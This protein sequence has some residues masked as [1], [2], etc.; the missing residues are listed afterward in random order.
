MVAYSTAPVEEAK[1]ES[2]RWTLL[3]WGLLGA[4]LILLA[5][6]FAQGLGD[7]SIQFPDADRILMDGVFIRDLIAA[8]PIFRPLEFA[9]T[10]Y[11][12]YPALSL[13]YRPPLFSAVAAL[14]HLGFGV[15]MWSGRLA[16]IALAMLGAGAWYMIVR[17]AYGRFAAALN[18]A[19]LGT[20]PFLVEWSY[21]TMA[22]VPTL[23]V[24]LVAAAF[25]YF[26]VEQ[27]KPW[28]IYAAAVAFAAAVWTKQ[29]AVVIALWL[30][31]YALIRWRLRDVLAS[32][33][34][35]LAGLLAAVLAAP[36]IAVSLYLGDQQLAQSVGS[37]EAG[38][39]AGRWTLAKWLFY[40]DALFAEQLTVV[41]GVLF[42]A[43]LAL[44]LFRRDRRV[45]F[46]V[47]A[48]PGIYIFFSLLKHP[49]LARYAIFWLPS[50]IAI[51]VLPLHE[52]FRSSATWPRAAAAAL[53]VALVGYQGWTALQVEP[54][55]VTGF[56][57]AARA[58]LEQS[59]SRAILIHS[60]TNGYFTF[61]VR[62]ADPEQRTF[63]LRSD[64]LFTASSVGS[65][66]RLQVFADSP[67]EMREILLKHGIDI[68][69]A[70]SQ[71]FTGVKAQQVFLDY[72]QH[73]PDFERLAAIPIE[74]NT[75]YYPG[76]QVE[77]Y[78]FLPSSAAGAKPADL[79][80]ALPVIGKRI[81]VP[82]EGDAYFESID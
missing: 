44:A 43:G 51:A 24:S 54:R 53:A 65:Q 71:D 47:L 64:K 5:L 21:Y 57:Q 79:R 67:E 49:G 60:R 30:L 26:F 39:G 1:R 13:G 35:W 63:V 32:R 29:T 18:V 50:A 69:V 38:G 66:N 75:S 25:F 10:Y 28:Q 40:P 78:R 82:A 55:F 42:V 11:A 27:R 8:F 19:L 17:H 73:S 72:L 81:V 12:Q 52:L 80:L 45:L 9:L 76:Q 14:F 36:I 23:A 56:D 6:M 70:D 16:L 58:A 48:F 68:V 22:E 3:D 46:F 77:I 74:T 62:Q 37:G 61:F 41:L 2:G 59:R 34:V 7:S 31:P 15:E 20:A 4:G 33:H